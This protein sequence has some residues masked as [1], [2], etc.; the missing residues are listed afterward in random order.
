MYKSISQE[1]ERRKNEDEKQNVEK[2]GL[3][4]I[5][6]KGKKRDEQNCCKREEEEVQRTQ[7]E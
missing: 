4:E 5:R 7:K 1:G 2:K 3:E 6:E